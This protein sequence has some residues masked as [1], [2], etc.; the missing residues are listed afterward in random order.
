[1]S[2]PDFQ[3]KLEKYAEV[4]IKV[5]LNLQPGQ[6]LLIGSSR[7]G[8][9][10][11]FEAAP[12]VREIAAKAYQAGSPLVDVIWGDPQLHV[13]RLQN[14]ARETL[15]A[16]PN[17]IA[18]GNL[19]HVKQG[20]ALL[21]IVA[22]DPDLFKGQ[23]PDMIG[24]LQKVAS[25]QNQELG[26]LISRWTT[27]WLLVSLPT[28]AW[29]AKIFPNV[30]AE[31]QQ[32][33][34]WEAIFKI[35]RIDQ[36][37]PVAAW[38]DHV[39][40]LGAVT[41]YLNQ[42]RYSAMRL[43]AP[44][45]DVTIGLA[46]GHIW[47]GGSTLGQNGVSFIP[48]VPTEEVFTM[49]HKDRVNGV[50]KATKPLNYGGVLIEDFSVTFENGRAVKVNADKGEST[51]QKMIETDEGAASLG[52]IALVPH[53]SPISQSGLL[54]YN[55]LFDE[56]AANHVALGRAYPDTMKGG[57]ALSAEDFGAAGGNVSLIHVDFMI[58]SGKMDVD[59]IN[60]DGSSEPVMRQGE[61]AFKV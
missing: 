45:T 50:V 13:I 54:F 48:N 33:R 25:E 11:P 38:N 4:I 10:T 58:G 26:I 17:W 19:N 39:Q 20:G 43:T 56:N 12:L 57:S 27:N 7:F 49:P 30:P 44:G 28:P 42:K 59:G 41:E 34:L 2:V 6:R 5:G 35:C 51:L 3:H 8:R 53:S 15:E 37:D 16:Y 18:E 24:V 40:K 1:M 36:D 23:D 47:F 21:G 29:A 22:N 46:E 14:A 31:E 9:E 61:W 52:E 32:D 55:T 60:A